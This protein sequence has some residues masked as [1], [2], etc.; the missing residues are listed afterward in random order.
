M[1]KT[2]DRS[3]EQTIIREQLSEETL[4]DIFLLEQCDIKIKY[5]EEMV[6]HWQKLHKENIDEKNK[7]LIKSGL[8]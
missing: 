6:A 1:K 8:M 3:P 5:S 7:I 4:K 2:L